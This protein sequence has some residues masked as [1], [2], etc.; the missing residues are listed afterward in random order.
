MDF[1][2]LK[3]QLRELPEPVKYKKKKRGVVE[4]AKGYYTIPCSMDS[5]KGDVLDLTPA[6]YNLYWQNYGHYYSSESQFIEKLENIDF[7]LSDKPHRVTERW[8]QYLTKWLK[9]D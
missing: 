7:W 4:E 9:K 6:E 2:E 3:K 8:P 1:E 5:F